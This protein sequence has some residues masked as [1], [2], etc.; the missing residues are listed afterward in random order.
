MHWKKAN[1]QLI[2]LLES[3]MKDFIS[4]R[5]PMFGAPT[6]FIRGNMFAGVHEDSVI[7]RLSD[8]DL[9]AIMARYPEVKPFTPMGGHVMK[10]YAALPENFMSN[11]EVF[12]SWLKKSY[13][14]AGSIPPKVKKAGTAKKH[15][16]I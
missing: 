13:A 14:Y 2:A 4:E 15:D 16:G 10:E 7:L 3:Q 8:S 6:F 1:P 9:K 11:S 5:R 12:K